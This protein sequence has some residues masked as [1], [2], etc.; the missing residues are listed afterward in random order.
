MTVY[1]Q[2]H[3][4]ANFIQSIFDV[5]S[6]SG[7]DGIQ[8]QTVVVG[9]DGR[10]YNPEAIQIIARMAAANGFARVLGGLRELAF[11]LRVAGLQERARRRFRHSVDRA[12]HR[13]TRAAHHSVCAYE[14]A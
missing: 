1:S 4:V 12:K 13:Y 8:G 10:F 3:Y 2:P 11:S 5:M 9:G 14:Q 7:D 6:G